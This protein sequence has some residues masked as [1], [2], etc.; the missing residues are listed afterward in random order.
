MNWRTGLPEKSG[1][2]VVLTKTRDINTWSFSGKH[3]A[4]NAYDRQTY[5]FALKHSLN[6]R[7]IKWIPL[8]EFLKDQG[9]YE[10]IEKDFAN[11]N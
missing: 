2:Y 6:D 3:K 4:F 8:D 5:E 1:D 11:E 7:V 10:S 9:L